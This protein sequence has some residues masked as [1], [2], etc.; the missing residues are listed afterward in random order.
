MYLQ[1]LAKASAIIPTACGAAADPRPCIE[2]PRYQPVCLLG[3]RRL[4]EVATEY[5]TYQ[6]ER[7]RPGSFK[8][9]RF[10]TELLVSHLGGTNKLGDITQARGRE[11]LSLIAQLSPN[12]RKYSEGA[13]R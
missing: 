3:D 8:A 12:V 13:V 4:A 6:S 9:V 7:L 1:T 5:L 10:A 11:V 2:R